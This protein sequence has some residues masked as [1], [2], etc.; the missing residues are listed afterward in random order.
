MKNLSILVKVGSCPLSSEVSLTCSTD[1]FLIPIVSHEKGENGYLKSSL[2][3]I[4]KLPHNQGVRYMTAQVNPNSDFNCDLCTRITLIKNNLQT[5]NFGLNFRGKKMC[6]E[7]A[8]ISGLWKI[9][10]RFLS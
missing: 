9:C 10:E 4:P 3:N 5:K 1:T 8:S 6:F 7:S 2:F